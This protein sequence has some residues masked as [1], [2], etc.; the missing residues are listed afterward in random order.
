MLTELDSESFEAR[1]KAEQELA[2]FGDK[3]EPAL[4][5]ALEAQPSPE[6]RKRVEGLLA[7]LNEP[8]QLSPLVV[9]KLRAVRVLEQVGTPAARAVLAQL[10]DG[11]EDPALGAEACAA[12]KRF[13]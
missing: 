12:L 7:R 1:E 8:P 4:R 5:A 10:A 13:R 2:R 11:F 6:V 9:E 3:A